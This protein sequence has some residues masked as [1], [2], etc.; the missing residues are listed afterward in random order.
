MF[1]FPGLISV[2]SDGQEERGR[3]R[4][5]TLRLLDRFQGSAFCEKFYRT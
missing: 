4:F 1:I 3:V 2:R 5:N